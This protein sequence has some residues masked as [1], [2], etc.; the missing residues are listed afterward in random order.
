MIE[1]HIPQKQLSK[2]S[3]KNLSEPWITQAIR[4]SISIKNTLYK[5]FMRTRSMYYYEKFK[6]YRN[7]LKQLIKN[8]K[9]D[10]YN[11]HFNKNTG[12]KY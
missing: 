5:T 11:K 3:I 10:Y 12:D 2:K 7:M 4:K 9:K 8:S 6:I 1:K